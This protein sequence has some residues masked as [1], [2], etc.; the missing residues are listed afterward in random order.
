VKVVAVGT[1]IQIY[2][3]DM[4]TPKI[5]FTDSSHVSGAIGLRAYNSAARFDNITARS[6]P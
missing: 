6:Q 3:T 2:V 4:S 1:L 5:S